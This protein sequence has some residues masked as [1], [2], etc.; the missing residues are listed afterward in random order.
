MEQLE[1]IIGTRFGVM[2]AQALISECVLGENMLYMVEQF[3][4]DKVSYRRTQDD[5]TT[6]Y[7]KFDRTDVDTEGRGLKLLISV[8]PTWGNTYLERQDSLGLL[9]RFISYEELRHKLQDPTMKKAN[10]SAQLEK[11]IKTF[12]QRDMT[13]LF[14]LP[15]GEMDP[16]QEMEILAQGGVVQC[17]GDPIEHARTHLLQANSP[18]LAQA[19]TAGK[20]DPK[21]KTNLL[22]LVQ[23]NMARM[24]AFL[25]DP[26]GA[27]A[28][29]LNRAGLVHP[30]AQS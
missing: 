22:L 15:T 25:K 2:A 9:D 16:A 27:A 11:V 12:G 7:K 1:S 24:S 23:E 8:D 3:H 29:R 6:V 19:M 10:I 30:G 28:E 26:Q 5:G 4:M 21:T 13:G 20:A 14:S 18:G 17:K